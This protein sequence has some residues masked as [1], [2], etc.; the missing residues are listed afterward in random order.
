[1][2]PRNPKTYRLKKITKIEGYLLDE[3]EV[4]KRLA[5]KMKLLNIVRRVVEIGLVTLTVITAG[6]SIA[7]F[8]SGVGL[9][10]GIALSKTSL[11]F[12]HSK[13]ITQ[14][15]FRKFTIKQEKKYGN[16]L[17]TQRKLY[18]IADIISQAMQDG[19]ISSI[20]F[21]KVLQEVQKYCKLKNDIR[22]QAKNKVK[23]IKKNNGK[24]CLNKEEM[25]AWK[26]FYKQSQ[27]LQILTVLMP[28]KT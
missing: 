20:E 24:N 1:M 21:N 22:N 25:K 13:V 10:F 17:I 11:T 16:K 9:S 4:C 27:I 2:P 28:F 23:H 26:T 14:K 12:S 18:S 19:D 7:A 8:T 3:T 6:A 5:K 15:S